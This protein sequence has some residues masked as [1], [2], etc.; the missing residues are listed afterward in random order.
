MGPDRVE[1]ASDD[2][3][4]NAGLFAPCNAPSAIATARRPAHLP[5][6]PVRADLR[7]A[8]AGL[9]LSSASVTLTAKVATTAVEATD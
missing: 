4:H 1:E 3:C 2:I 6:F 8:A 7:N 5:P 9:D